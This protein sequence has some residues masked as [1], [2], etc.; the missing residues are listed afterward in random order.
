[1]KSITTHIRYLLP[2]VVLGVLFFT[3]CVTGPP[4][5]AP[6]VEPVTA[7][8][9]GPENG[10]APFDAV[11]SAEGPL[12]LSVDDAVL[13]GLA[14][15]RALRVEVLR[16]EIQRARAAEAE[17]RFEPW[18]SGSAGTGRDRIA[19]RTE[20][21]LAATQTERLDAGWEIVKP[22]AFGGTLGIDAGWRRDET[23]VGGWE[24]H[25]LRA[26][27]SATQPLLRGAGR[28]VNLAAIR[29][30]ER[31]VRMSD[32]ELQA[33]AEAVMAEI[34]SVYWEYA[35]ATRRIEI[36]RESKLLAEQQLREIERRIE[37]GALAET[38]RAAARAE[39]ALRREALINARSTADALRYRIL[40]L[41]N[42]PG[43]WD[44][45]V[46]LRDDPVLPDPLPPREKPA[47]RMERALEMRP[48]LRQARWAIEQGE[49]DVVQTRSGLLPRLDLFLRL[50]RTAYA[51]SFSDAASD[52]DG[53]MDW[54]AGVRFEV[55]LGRGAERA[56]HQRSVL[57][58]H[59]AEEALHN[60]A[61]TVQLDIRTASIELERAAEQIE[62]T[63][64]TRTL[65]EEKLRAEEQK[66]SVG[67]STSLLV[68]QAQRDVMAGRIAE[69]EAITLYLRALVRLH[70]LEGTL[71]ERRGMVLQRGTT[72]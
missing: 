62:A 38:E 12:V 59:Q 9:A 14:R 35:L 66:F 8:A 13:Y 3:A 60:L 61:Q 48:E 26:G 72:P 37:V 63:A 7:D 19:S 4:L 41:L 43:D 1:M 34:E 24:T 53:D 65:Q 20:G 71:L 42:A 32:Y 58:R 54:S 6:R 70:R 55:P 36:V 40:R 28:K 67:R 46:T 22:T 50:G 27:L 17:A 5:T 52:G 15:N 25:R 21:A 69:V 57:T 45:V 2:A 49:L 16:P 11:L 29:Q 68:A 56:R 39:V 51:D 23:P 30:A 64:A 10:V 18:L 44:R 31:A 47:R 33:F